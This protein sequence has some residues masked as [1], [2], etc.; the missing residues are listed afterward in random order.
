MIVYRKY[1]SDAETPVIHR[2]I[3]YANYDPSSGL[4]NVP[5]LQGLTRGKDWDR[6]GSSQSWNAISTL[7]LF[8]VGYGHKNITIN[9]AS[10]SKYSGYVTM[11][12][13]AR[14]N[15][16]V[17][18]VNIIPNKLIKFDWI[19]GEARGELPWFGLIKLCLGSSSS[20]KQNCAKA[21]PNSMQG[22][23]VAIGVLVAM[24]VMYDV[25][26]NYIGRKEEDTEKG[27]AMRPSPSIAAFLNVI[28]PGTGHM[29]SNVKRW[30]VV[31]AY[32]FTLYFFII[33]VLSMYALGFPVVGIAALL[34]INVILAIHVY[35]LLRR[36][37]K[38]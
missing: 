27:A 14:T 7:R 34:V 20:D 12:D 26:R 31:G 19:V 18:Q 22:L 23:W 9:F 37:T 35:H 30:N 11:G 29:Y 17:D 3:L 33:E 32:I 16:E 36:K 8:N 1:G 2:A 28:L 21:P 5:E 25:S 24:P 13:N 6:D 38:R 4:F 15:S 10:M